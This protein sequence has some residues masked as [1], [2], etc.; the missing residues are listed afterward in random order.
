MK[1]SRMVR[2]WLTLGAVSA[3]ALCLVLSLCAQNLPEPGEGGEPYVNFNFDQVEIRLIAKLA[4]DITG[5]R[6]VVD[7]NVTGK[8]TVVTPERVATSEVFPLFLSILESSGYS[9]VE[10]DNTYHVVALP[11]TTIPVGPV[12]G[13]EAETPAGGIVTKVLKLDHISAV[14][15][16]KALEPMIRGAKEGSIAAVGSTN[17]LIITDT[18]DN[19]R[20]VEQIIF[21]LDQPGAS[22]T[23]EFLQLEH[24]SAKDVALQVS[25]AMQ[26]AESAGAALSRNMRQ[27]TEGGGA[28]PSGFTVVP[29]VQA[30]GV[31]LVGTPVQLADAKQLISSMDVEG[32]AGSGRLNA[33]FL[34]YLEAEEA[35]LNL[36]ALLEK[37]V[38]Q[39][40]IN[41]IAI[42]PNVSNNAL[43]IDASP[44]DFKLVEELVA[45]LDTPPDLVLV[46]ILIAEVDI[47]EGFE[48]G[49]ELAT[50][51]QPQEDSTTVIGRSLPG[52][53]STLLDIV[54]NGMFPQ[55][56]TFGLA[57][58][59]PIEVNGVLIPQVPILLTALA[60]DREIRIH[61]NIPLLAQDNREAT[62]S[63]VENIPIL[64][65]TIEG[66]A[67]TAR[68]VIQN[69]E[70]M[71]VGITL[72]FTPHVNPHGE[73][74]MDLNPSIETVVDETSGDIPFTPTIARRE[75][76]TTVTVSN[77]QTVAIS[78][79]IRED[80]ITNVSKVPLLGDIPVLGHLFRKT[81]DQ[82]RRSNLLILVTPHIVTELEASR[83]M[84]E[85]LE[86]RTGVLLETNAVS[87]TI[88]GER[89]R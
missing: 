25:L 73:I 62:V 78:G 85:D 12:I 64:T 42:V 6:F 56:L 31:I 59:E 28:I 75:V 54:T 46:E 60:Q 26:G 1:I 11:E 9:V 83:L 82:K 44:R 58:G 61:A 57:R 79:L 72:T 66:G 55:G 2:R 7:D 13:P 47:G 16:K 80:Q 48:L 20:R 10:R 65:S 74:L 52:D 53:S 29:S 87:R 50:I 23:T 86:K 21:E 24:A 37:T 70:R 22:R 14:E 38:G 88:L 89:R 19:I 76:S 71:D 43:I 5:K 3:A 33:V 36:N 4:G 35:A 45:S 40:Q 68:D 84:R 15:V 81:T 18:A 41:D 17:H 67:G 27:V 32:P 8:V 39:E 30:N 34:D 51:E 69:I 77:K 49:V 63:V